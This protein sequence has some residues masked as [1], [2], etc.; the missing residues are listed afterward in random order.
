[1]R[2]YDLWFEYGQKCVVKADTVSPPESTW[3]AQYA[4][5][6]AAEVALKREGLVPNGG[7]LP[8]DEGPLRTPLVSDHLYSKLVSNMRCE[9]AS[10]TSVE[11]KV[12][13]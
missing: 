12:Q 1:M 8:P 6:E 7:I 10:R 4:S 3:A 2:Q 11:L 13:I 5:K 9:L